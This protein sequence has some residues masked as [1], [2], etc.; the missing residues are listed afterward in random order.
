MLG[1]FFRPLAPFPFLHQGLPLDR[2]YW[3]EAARIVQNCESND[4]LLKLLF[5]AI[6]TIEKLTHCNVPIWVIEN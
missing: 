2:T 4:F 3:C 5:I 1:H 6:F